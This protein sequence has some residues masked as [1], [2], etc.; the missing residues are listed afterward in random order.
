LA[1]D[2]LLLNAALEK[3]PCI[4]GAFSRWQLLQLA[5]TCFSLLQL[6]SASIG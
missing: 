4:A 5:S 1:F 2:Q 3:E 6:A